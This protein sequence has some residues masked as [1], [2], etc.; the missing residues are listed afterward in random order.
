MDFY[1]HFIEHF[2]FHCI[3][4]KYPISCF[5]D[6]EY[7]KMELD[8]KENHYPKELKEKLLKGETLKQEEEDRFENEYGR[9]KSRPETTLIDIV[10]AINAGNIELFRFN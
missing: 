9:Y 1:L 10:A 4:A 3:T 6:I 5:I 8:K 7:W 2:H